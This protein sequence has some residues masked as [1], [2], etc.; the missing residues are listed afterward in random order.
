[1]VT[2]GGTRQTLIKCRFLGNSAGIAGGIYNI[3]G[4][5]LFLSNCLFSGNSANSG[6][7]IETGGGAQRSDVELTNCTFTKNV[8]IGSTGGVSL[9]ERGSVV[10]MANCILWGN[11][12]G[13]DSTES[14]QIRPGKVIISHCCVQA[15]SGTFGGTANSGLD[16]LFVDPNGPDHKIGTL[17]DNLRL[18]PA[19]PCRDAGDNSSLA[20]DTLDLDRDGDPN[21][22]IPF[23]LEGRPRVQ[24]GRVDI[25]A[26]ES[27]SPPSG[28]RL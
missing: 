17:D 18:T 2:D 5:S 25:G 19:S 28:G 9:G 10:T 24:N 20:R 15:W 1:M 26:Y 11:T 13:R 21:E 7:A 6:G 8:G 4:C 23:D 14:A 16:P 27:D 3:Y 12:D 22:P